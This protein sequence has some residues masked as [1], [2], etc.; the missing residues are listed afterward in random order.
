MLESHAWWRCGIR[1]YQIQGG[2]D[3]ALHIGGGGR[4]SASRAGPR[5]GE[6]GSGV[7]PHS[8]IPIRNSIPG[9]G[10]PGIPTTGFPRQQRR[11]QHARGR[12][13][14]VMVHLGREDLLHRDSCHPAPF[15]RVP[16]HRWVSPCFLLFAPL[17]LS[18][19]ANPCQELSI[20]E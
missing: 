19:P 13:R 1:S 20:E 11:W 8:G 5:C 16:S 15:S 2:R 18:P 6:G 3:E 14:P 7:R 4:G 12:A 9:L 17:L 10:D